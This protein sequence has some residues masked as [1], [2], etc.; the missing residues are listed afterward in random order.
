M[1][2]RDGGNNSCWLFLLYV[3]RTRVRL[4]RFGCIRFVVALVA[5]GDTGRRRLSVYLP[6]RVERYIRTISD[7]W[8]LISGCVQR[9]EDVPDRRA[10]SQVLPLAKRLGNLRFRPELGQGFI[11]RFW[12]P[13]NLNL[14]LKL[15]LGTIC[16]PFTMGSVRLSGGF[17]CLVP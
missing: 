7:T 1:A 10:L 3:P 17:H 4:T 12:G 5:L 13:Q 15:R 8:L 16:L 2:V 11:L 9:T 6:R 14:E